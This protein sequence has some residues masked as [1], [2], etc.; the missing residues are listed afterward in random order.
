LFAP[1][2]PK[3]R[4]PK[5]REKPVRRNFVPLDDGG[6]DTTMLFT[7]KTPRVAALKCARRGMK[8]I[9][10]RETNTNKVHAFTGKVKMEKRTEDMPDWLPDKVTV[11]HVK[12]VSTYRLLPDG[13]KKYP[14]RRKPKKK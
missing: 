4:K 3:K 8:S 11:P 9:H 6:R 7:G 14:Y 12:K 5:R 1:D 13:S 2:P 10:L